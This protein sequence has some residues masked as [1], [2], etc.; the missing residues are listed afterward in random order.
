M[1]LSLLTIIILCANNTFAQDKVYWKNGFEY[2]YEATYLD[3]NGDTLSVENV[4]IKATD[5]IFN[6]NQ[7]LLYYSYSLDNINLKSKTDSILGFNKKWVNIQGEG[8][9]EGNRLWIHPFRSNQYILT[10]IAPF[11]KVTLPPALNI[12]TKGKTKIF[13]TFGNF[14]G[15]VKS[16]TIITAQETRNYNWGTELNC[17]KIES[18][19]K[20]SKL[21]TSYLI[22]YF[23]ENIGILEMNYLFYNGEKMNFKLLQTKK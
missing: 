23:K 5:T 2:L 7:T 18:V 11:P 22:V 14:K 15:T 1:K 19:G 3:K 10:E 13:S 6:Y 21:G 20:H 12:M 8:A 16:T 17:W 9:L 4:T